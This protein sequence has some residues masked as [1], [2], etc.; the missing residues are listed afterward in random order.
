MENEGEIFLE[1]SV[2]K[3]L[4]WII[5]ILNRH[6][7][8]F[9]VTGGL[10]ARLYGGTRPLGDIDLD[11]P[12]DRFD[13]IL[14]EVKPYLYFGPAIYTDDNW[15]VSLITLNYEGQDIDLGGAYQ[16]Q[17]FDP[18][19]Q[20]WV[21]SPANLGNVRIVRVSD[22]EIPV[23]DAMDF[24]CYKEKLNRVMDTEDIDAVKNWLKLQPKH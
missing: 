22:L 17:I 21:D 1:A 6:H 7:I 24:I 15:K 12:E 20:Q 18:S 2:L 4:R 14:S 10:A 9:Q 3:S 5:G 16:T 23:V 11:I 8:P 19:Q 13:E